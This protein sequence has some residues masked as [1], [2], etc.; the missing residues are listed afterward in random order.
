[1]TLQALRQKIGDDAFFRI[2]RRWYAENKYGNVTTADF[3][4]LSEQV[5]GQQLDQFFEVWLYTPAKPTSW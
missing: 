1:M 3:V 2:L 4:A 5:S